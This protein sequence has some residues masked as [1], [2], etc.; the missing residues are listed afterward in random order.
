MIHNAILSFICLLL[1]FHGACAAEEQTKLSV[2]DL[3]GEWALNEDASDNN[4][5]LFKGKL[6]KSRQPIPRFGTSGPGGPSIYD[7]AQ[8][9]YW[10]TIADGQ[11]RR[12]QKDLRRLGTAYPLI[13][14][15]DLAV[16]ATELG[17]EFQYDDVLLRLVK[18]NPGGRTFSAKG[19]ELVEDTFGFTLAYWDKQQLVLETDPPDGGKIVEKIKLLGNGQLE[20]A[21]RIKSRALKEPVTVRRVFDRSS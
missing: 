21:I 5:K 15:A 12:A 4:K 2:P 19:D 11:E 14:A 7:R 6:R 16:R 10:N 20:Y 13:T 17:F 3:F 18:P 8:A 1:F 9:N